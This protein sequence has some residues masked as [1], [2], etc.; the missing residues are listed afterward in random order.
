[1]RKGY[2]Y[3]ADRIGCCADRI[4]LLCRTDT[5]VARNGYGCTVVVRNGYGCCAERI[6]LLCGT[7]TEALLIF[8]LLPLMKGCGWMTCTVIIHIIVMH[9]K[10]K[11]NSL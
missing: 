4:R 2:G 5:V 3:C 7:D 1:M 11:T 10:K 6:R 9:M 8:R